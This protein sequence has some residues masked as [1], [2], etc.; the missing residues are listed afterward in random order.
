MVRNWPDKFLHITILNPCVCVCDQEWLINYAEELTTSV[1][2]SRRDNVTSV[3]PRKDFTSSQIRDR[4]SSGKQFTYQ[5]QFCIIDLFA[6]RSS[7]CKQFTY[8][9]QF[10]ILDLFHMRSRSL[11]IVVQAH[12]VSSMSACKPWFRHKY[13]LQICNTSSLPSSACYDHGD[14]KLALFSTYL[15]VCFSVSSYRQTKE[16]FLR[17]VL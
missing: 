2:T 10:C 7:S 3:L 16:W 1:S 5:T 9:T 14:R 13:V 4:S 17:H 11:W 6:D 12:R 15:F 8:Q